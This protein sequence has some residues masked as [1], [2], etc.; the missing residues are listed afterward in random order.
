MMTMTLTNEDIQKIE[1]FNEI[2]QHGYWVNGR[3]VTDVYNRVMDKHLAP[4][5]CS[6]CIRHRIS[7]LVK[8]M[9]RYKEQLETE[10]IEKEEIKEEV[11]VEEQPKKRGRKK[12]KKDESQ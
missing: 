2:M 9:R 11:V 4:T 6:S 5:S 7:E 12:V 1:R 3:E 10:P 8:L